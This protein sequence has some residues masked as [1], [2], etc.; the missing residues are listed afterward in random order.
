MYNLFQYTLENI[1]NHST[2]ITII[3][4]NLKKMFDLNNVKEIM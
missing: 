1:Y 3:F 4:F 2:I